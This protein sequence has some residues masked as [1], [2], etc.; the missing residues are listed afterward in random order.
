MTNET[1]TPQSAPRAPQRPTIRSHHGDEVVDNYEWLRDKDNPDTIAYLEE[2]NAWTSARTDHLE[3]LRETI[4]NEIK[5]RVLETDMSVPSRVGNWWYF[6]RTTEGKQYGAQ[7]RVPV[8]S[9]DDWTPPTLEPGVTLPGEQ[10]IFDANE[11]AAGTD[12]FSLGSFSVDEAGHRLAYA[13]DTTGDERYTLRIRDLTTG[14]DLPGAIPNTSGGAALTPDGRFVFYTTV[15]DA[16]R[17]DT[18]WRHE[19][20]TD[21]SADAVV[22]RE[23]DDRFWVGVGVSRTNRYLHIEASSKVTSETALIDLSEP[24]ANPVVVWERREGVEYSVEHAVDA[25]G[26]DCLLIC[27]NDG[28][29]DFAIART[30]IPLAGP[31]DPGE[32]ALVLTPEPGQRIE[33]V[34]AFASFLA[35]SYRDQAVPAVAVLGVAEALGGPGSAPWQLRS[36]RFED[37]FSAVGIAG[38]GQFDQPLLRLGVSS[39]ITPARVIDYEVAT[40]AAHVRKVQPVLGGYDPSRYGQ[41]RLWARADDGTQVPISVVWRRDLVEV[42]ADGVPAAP[43]PLR[44][45]GYG[46][47]EASLD[48]GLSIPRLSALDRGVVFAIA[49][50]RGGGEL[51]REWYE[52]GRMLNK[53]NTFTDFVACAR[54]L[55]DAGWT[56]PDRMV[57]EGGSA[58]GLLIG[59]VVNLAPE[60]FAGAVADVPFVDA[61]TS[62]LD[63]SLPL[64]VIEWDEW[65]DPLHDADVYAYMKSYSPYENVRAGVRYPRILAVTSLH[66]TRVLYVEPAKWVARLRE[67]GADVLLK[68]EMSAGHGGVSGRY[69]QWR[70]VAFELAWTLDVLGA[71][72]VRPHG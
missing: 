39:F 14:A 46:A 56:A 70:E 62:I 18:V 31:L 6:A 4:F 16:W 47:Y 22:F 63:P 9:A 27:H 24:T 29:Q 43:A 34:D 71:T 50:V 21:P 23:D 13:T 28:Y 41:A 45:Y 69:A 32:A 36:L 40:G 37:E 48:P 60:L 17:P 2:E 5:S 57:A 20:G 25:T 38:S 35:V 51:G 72:E 30:G 66:D 12:F 59:A 67:V 61:L 42:G 11:E 26:S 15:D 1:T 7:S 53:K 8:R 3:P 52:Q 44:I 33:G 10:V 68:T 58:G 55:V 54:H 19:V 65:G 49:H 64:T